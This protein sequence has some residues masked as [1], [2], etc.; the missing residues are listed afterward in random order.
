MQLTLRHPLLG[1][2][3]GM[4]EVANAGFTEETTG[5]ASFNA[6]HQTHNTFTQ[7]S[8]EDGLPGLFLYCLTL[9][10][11]FRIVRSVEKRAR[12]YP[13][14]SSVR[15]MAIALRLSLIAFTGTALFA[16]TAYGY[17]LPMLAALCVA[18]DRATAELF[19]SQIPS[20]SEQPK[21]MPQAAKAPAHFRPGTLGGTKKM[22]WKRSPSR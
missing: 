5:H 8:S 4:F 6:W 14:L 20:G 10:F 1:V 16:S 21:T 13:A 2:G 17:Y 9:L 22:T 7:V 15:H 19:L 12:Q 3:P 11:C 18:L